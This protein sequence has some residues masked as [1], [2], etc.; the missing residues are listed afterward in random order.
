MQFIIQ[1]MITFSPKKRIS[2]NEAHIAL[3]L[4]EIINFYEKTTDKNLLI[5][6]WGK[7][8]IKF[9]LFFNLDEFLI[10]K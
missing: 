6:S 3:N 7:N 10:N 8:F 2:I 4:A 5:S 1:K 9:L